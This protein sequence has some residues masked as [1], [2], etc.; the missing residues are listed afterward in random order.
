M[1]QDLY[2]QGLSNPH[3]AFNQGA[4]REEA[5]TVGTRLFSSLGHWDV[6]D[7]AIY[8]FG[9]CGSGA[10]NAWSVAIDHG[11]TLKNLWSRSRLGLRAAIA[12]GDSNPNDADLQTFNPL[13]VRGNYFSEAGLLSPQNF[14]DLFPSLRIKPGSKLTA[15]LGLDIHWRENLGD[16]IYQPGGSVIFRGNLDF[17]RFVGNELVLGMAWQLKRQYLVFRRLFSF[18]RRAIYSPEQRGRR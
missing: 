12:T 2:Y 15:E 7:E 5:H 13:F 6:N 9:Q 11:F 1:Q 16:G 18:L 4:G 17:A 8:Q 3:A 14:I 10:V